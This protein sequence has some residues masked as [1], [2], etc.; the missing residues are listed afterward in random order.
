M[1]YLFL[2]HQILHMWQGNFACKIATKDQL[3]YTAQAIIIVESSDCRFRY[4]DDGKSLGCMQVSLGATRRVFPHFP[5]SEWRLLATDDGLN[6]S[7]G[8]RYLSLCMQQMGSWE[9]G[10]VCYNA[11]P[12][13]AEHLSPWEVSHFPYVLAVQK[14]V[15]ILEQIEPGKS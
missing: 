12:S 6:I 13:F 7:L 3:C 15:Q 1:I 5:A 11:G 14:Y 8:T 9:R 10:L 4:G 2:A